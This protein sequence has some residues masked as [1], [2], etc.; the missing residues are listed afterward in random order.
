MT[1]RLD[2]RHRPRQCMFGELLAPTEEFSHPRAVPGST[3]TDQEAHCFVRRD[4]AAHFRVPAHCV[5][6]LRIGMHRHIAGV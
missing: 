5:A 3:L 2:S 1:T 4:P 6:D